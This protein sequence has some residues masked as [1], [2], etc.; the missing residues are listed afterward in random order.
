MN[1]R[2]A[3]RAVFAA[4]L[5]P[6]EKLVL[7]CIIDHWSRK[8]PVPFPG[9]ATLAKQTGLQRRTVIAAVRSLVARDVMPDPVARDAAGKAKRGAP[10][11]YQIEIAIPRLASESHRQPVSDLHH[12][13]EGERVPLL[14]QDRCPIRTGGGAL[15]R[16][17]QHQDGSRSPEESTEESTEESISPPVAAEEPIPVLALVPPE[18]KPKRTG[19]STSKAT[20]TDTPEQ[21]PKPKL[22]PK[23]KAEPKRTPEQHEAHAAIVA[24]HVAIVLEATGE[25][26]AEE[27]GAAWKLLDAMKGDREIAIA[28]IREAVGRGTYG[29]TSLAK[30][31]GKPNDYIPRRNGGRGQHQG[32]KQPNSGWQ[33]PTE[34]L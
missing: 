11:R 6:S 29:T 24:A 23:K 28:R 31:A 19:K 12:P 16:T 13:T 10:H 18:P 20:K 9:L 8:F 26:P 27:H 3:V 15:L 4:D 5:R 17:E 30:I 33:P 21:S 22:K 2:A 34:N 14:H 25:K 32:P 1:Q 7:L